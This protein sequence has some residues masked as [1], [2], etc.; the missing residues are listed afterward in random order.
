MLLLCFY[1]RSLTKFFVKLNRTEWPDVV[2]I[3]QAACQTCLFSCRLHI[4]PDLYT[5]T[6]CS[7][8]SW[9]CVKTCATA[10]AGCELAESRLES[11][12]ACWGPTCGELPPVSATT[13]HS[14]LQAPPICPAFSGMAAVPCRPAAALSLQF[15]QG[16]SLQMSVQ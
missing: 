10:E 3:I 15:M 7:L 11:S 1:L 4:E 6:F 12:D 2:T 5:S 14:T 8:S 13:M 16:M 9:N